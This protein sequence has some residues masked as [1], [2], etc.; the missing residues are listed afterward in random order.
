MQADILF[1]VLVGKLCEQIR[2]KK[3]NH[4]FWLNIFS[5]DLIPPVSFISVWP[6]CEIH[7][8]VKVSSRGDKAGGVEAIR[9]DFTVCVLPEETDW[10][11]EENKDMNRGSRKGGG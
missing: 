7:S 4:S 1:L 5:S 9:I 11:E 2:E 10:G 6:S 3:S 8:Y